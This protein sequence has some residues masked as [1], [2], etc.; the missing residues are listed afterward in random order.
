MDTDIKP[1]KK[2]FFHR[3]LIDEITLLVLLGLSYTGVAITNISPGGS[4][5]FWLAM[6][7]V[8]FIASL[9]TEW[10]NVRTGKYPWKMV[11]WNHSL[12]WLAVLAAVQMVFAMQQIGR[13]NNEMTGLMLLLVLALSTFVAGIRLGWLFRLAGL[14]LGISLL[15]LVYV[16]RYLWILVALAILI[17]IIHHFLMRYIRTKQQHEI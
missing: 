10:K 14:F 7:P 5:R 8:F 4:H 13:L 1:P 16:E 2:T 6:V 3:H 11:L 9:V 17:L 15:M 12:Q